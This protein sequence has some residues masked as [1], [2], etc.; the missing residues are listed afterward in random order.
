MYST[1][2]KIA[3][4]GDFNS[5]S[6]VQHKDFIP[7]DSNRFL[8]VDQ[9][10]GLEFDNFRNNEDKHDNV[11]SKHLSGMCIIEWANSGGLD[12]KIYLP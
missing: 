6:G 1:L 8:P 4:G 2:G 10:V 3:L 11:N 7:L 9:T 12:R 5:R